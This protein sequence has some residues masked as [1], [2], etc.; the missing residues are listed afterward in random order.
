MLNMKLRLCAAIL[1]LASVGAALA[2]CGSSDAG[3][4]KTTEANT[5]VDTAAATEERLPLTTCPHSPKRTTAG[6]NLCS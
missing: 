5:A 2:S 4:A 6:K 1:A 3:D